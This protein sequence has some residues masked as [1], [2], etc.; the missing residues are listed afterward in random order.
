MAYNSK[1]KGQEIDE[2]LTQSSNMPSK[3]GHCRVTAD[4]ILQFFASVESQELYDTD[5]ES[6]ADLLLG[7][8]SI[9]TSGEIGRAHV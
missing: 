9:V 7:Q 6:H 3:F 4:N 5:P 2:L 1:F 8:T